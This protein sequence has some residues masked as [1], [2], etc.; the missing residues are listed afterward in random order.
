MIHRDLQNFI[1]NA[2]A[3]HYDA[4]DNPRHPL[5]VARF[6]AVCFTLEQY[7]LHLATLTN[8]AR[9]YTR[10]FKLGVTAKRLA[11]FNKAQA[12]ATLS[13]KWLEKFETETFT[14][15]WEERIKGVTNGNK[16]ALP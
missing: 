12:E 15:E 1:G 5:V 2:I 4:Y 10:L 16:S 11:N 14:K 8:F 7:P 13:F 9:A 6:G 3:R